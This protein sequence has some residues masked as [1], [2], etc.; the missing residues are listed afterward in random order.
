M[1]NPKESFSLFIPEYY[2]LEITHQALSITKDMDLQN[3]INKSKAAF[4]TGLI[5]KMAKENGIK[6]V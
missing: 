5:Q 4:F 3:K 6:T 2:P 1:R